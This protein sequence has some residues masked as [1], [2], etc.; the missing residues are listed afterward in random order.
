M[1]IQSLAARAAVAMGLALAMSGCANVAGHTQAGLGF[2]KAPLDAGT[3]AKA[4]KRGEACAQNVL[5]AVAWGDASI[6]TA[7]K[8]GGITQVATVE[9]LH[10]RVLGYYAKFCTVVHGD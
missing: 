6:D 9:Y 5:G 10:T 7:K 4:G 2:Y 8:A 1:T 3:T